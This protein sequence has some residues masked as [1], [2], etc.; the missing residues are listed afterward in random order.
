[1]AFPV[2]TPQQRAQALAKATAARKARSTLLSDI[3]TGQ[4]DPAT[5]LAQADTDEIIKRTKVTA[6]IRA[7]P[8]IGTV[9]AT[10][11]LEQLSI[12]ATRRIGGLGPSQRQALLDALT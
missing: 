10:R 6:L 3:R 5:V 2:T 11:L 1:M 12:P 7:V 8:G 4:R 9:K